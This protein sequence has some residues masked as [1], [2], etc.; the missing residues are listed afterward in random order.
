M[1]KKFAFINAGELL[2]SH[3]W[4]QI[5]SEHT[6]FT[7]WHKPESKYTLF[8]Y[9]NGEWHLNDKNRNVIRSG[10]D[11]ET[12]VALVTGDVKPIEHM[13]SKQTS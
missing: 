3:E 2:V 7:M 5:P 10:D 1:L 9:N 6:V 13:G 4:E 12:L 8:V 11:F